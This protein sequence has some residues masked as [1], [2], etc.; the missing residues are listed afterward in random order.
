VHPHGLIEMTSTITMDQV[1]KGNENH[2]QTLLLIDDTLVL[3]G[4]L[5]AGGGVTRLHP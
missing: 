1:C 4:R 2:L 5:D 3:S